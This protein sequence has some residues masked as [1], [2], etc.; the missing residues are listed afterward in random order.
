MHLN[1][2]G[3]GTAILLYFL[4]S[5]SD[6]SSTSSG[7][8][9]SFSTSRVGLLVS[10]DVVQKP[11]R[12]SFLT[13]TRNLSEEWLMCYHTNGQFISL[14]DAVYRGGIQKKPAGGTSS[15]VRG[16]TPPSGLGTFEPISSSWYLPSIAFCLTDVP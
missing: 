4:S 12:G 8:A 7:L 5:A 2:A 10:H 6:C 16:L 14:M 1:V 11:A 9:L 13:M 15:N 3:F